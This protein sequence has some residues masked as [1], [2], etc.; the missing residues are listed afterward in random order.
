MPIMWTTLIKRERK[1]MRERG[2]EFKILPK[3]IVSAHIS[4]L[5]RD[6]FLSFPS[7]KESQ[8]QGKEVNFPNDYKF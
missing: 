2:R 6:H 1:Q 7:L 5:A 4:Y 3:C 8:R